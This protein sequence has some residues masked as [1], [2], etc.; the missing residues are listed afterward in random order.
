MSRIAAEFH[1]PGMT[2]DQYD[3]VIRDF[4][5]AESED[6]NLVKDRV[7]HLAMPEDGGWLVFDVWESMEAFSGVGAILGPL[8]AK[9]GLQMTEPKI[10]PVHNTMT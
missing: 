2:A 9:H 3:K 10:Y 1:F 6:P 7:I 8:F 4:E 5:A